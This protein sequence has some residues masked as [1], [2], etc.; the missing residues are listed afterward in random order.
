MHFA[1][2]RFQ[3]RLHSKFTKWSSHNN[4][5][6]CDLKAFPK[7]ESGTDTS[8][9][10]VAGGIVST[11][12]IKSWQRSRQ[13]SGEA[14]WRMERRTLKYR[15]QENQENHRFSSSLHT[16]VSEKRIGREKHTRQSNVSQMIPHIFPKVHFAL[17]MKI[18][19]MVACL[20]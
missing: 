9:A 14:T 13:A 19:M 5:R 16:S 17:L 6:Q 2:F 10:C 1:L 8:L 7:K 20:N 4:I 15:L 18:K 3:C 12:E 11:H